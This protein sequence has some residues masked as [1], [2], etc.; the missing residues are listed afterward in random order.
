MVSWTKHSSERCVLL[1]KPFIEISDLR[2]ASAE[3]GPVARVNQQVTRWQIDRSVELMC[4]TKAC[5]LQDV[6]DRTYGF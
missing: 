4:V 5:N 3:A 6:P 2:Q 1:A